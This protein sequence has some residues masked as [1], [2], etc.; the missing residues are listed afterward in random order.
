M[1]AGFPTS[2]AR[3]SSPN[4]LPPLHETPRERVPW[5]AISIFTAVAF[6]LAWVVALPLWLGDANPVVMQ[7]VASAMMFTPAAAVLMVVFAMR[8]PRRGFW[9]F[10]GAW[11]LKPVG[12]TIWFCVLAIF[13]PIVLVLAGVAL[14]GA[15]GFVELDVA[16]LSGF[17]ALLEDTG[18]DTAGLPLHLIALMQLAMVPIVAIIPN[19]ILAFGEE[20]AWRGWLTSALRPW[21][22]WRSL[23][24]IGV[25]WGLWHAPLTLL[26]HN[27][28]RTD[29]GGVALMVVNCVMLGILLGWLRLRSGSV[30]PAVFAHGAL[31]GM[32]QVT[33]LV[34]AAGTP[35]DM[36]LI[37]PTGVAMWIVLAATIGVL[38]VTGQFRASRLTQRDA[39][40]G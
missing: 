2:G 3:S 18:A 14:S 27:Y 28:G 23:I 4:D 17:A 21:G 25:I 32:G 11:P 40:A 6:L 22:V 38:V 33:F 12:R 34:A 10:V 35:Y 36:A 19:G 30:W 29:V 9:R 13:G 16:N 1:S 37:A 26:G 15:L 31:N 24:L 20:I 5:P 39:H 7:L 8:V